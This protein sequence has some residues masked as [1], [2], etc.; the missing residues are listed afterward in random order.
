MPIHSNKQLAESDEFTIG[1]LYEYNLKDASIT[2]WQYHF[3]LPTDDYLS[4]PIN[5]DPVYTNPTAETYLVLEV[6]E[7]IYNSWGYSVKVLSS[8]G[9]VGRLYMRIK[10]WTKL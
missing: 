10:D 2:S 4:I 9:I 8:S 1:A 7:N 3:T 5:N 6:S